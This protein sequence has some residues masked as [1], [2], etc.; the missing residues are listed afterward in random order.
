MKVRVWALWQ[1]KQRRHTSSRMIYAFVS[2]VCGEW[3]T[4][5]FQHWQEK[6]WASAPGTTCPV[7]P[8]LTMTSLNT[9]LRQESSDM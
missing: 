2:E 9:R 1:D 6:R 5:A 8:C 4:V 3:T 7:Q